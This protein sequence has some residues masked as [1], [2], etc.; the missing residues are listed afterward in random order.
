ME[1]SEK[2]REKSYAI[3]YWS[4][5]GMGSDT[6]VGLITESDLR[7]LILMETCPDDEKAR[8][9]RPC[10]CVRIGFRL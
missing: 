8:T 2:A 10:I 3:T 7:E 1:Y 6:E 4:N 5:W 9:S